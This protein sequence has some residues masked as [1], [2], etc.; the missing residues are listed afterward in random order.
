MSR[1]RLTKSRPKIFNANQHNTFSCRTTSTDEATPY[2][3]YDVLL[4][5]GGTIS[6][7]KFTK[8]RV[9]TIRDPDLWPSKPFSKA[10][11]GQL[12][13]LMLSRLYKNE[14]SAN[15]SAPFQSYRPNHSPR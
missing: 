1:F 9:V 3:C 6:Y 10:T 11:I 7:K 14:T 8:L 15:A 5:N 4:H 12:S 13:M 2:R